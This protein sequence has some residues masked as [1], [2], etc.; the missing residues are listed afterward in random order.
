M[1]T[2]LR[3]R[4]RLHRLIS[5]RLLASDCEIECQITV[6]PGFDSQEIHTRFAAMKLWLEDFVDNSIA[7]NPDSEIDINWIS[8]LYNTAIM[9]PGE[10]MDHILAALI[11]AKL[12]AI[13]VGVVEISRTHF[14]CDTSHGFSNA[15]SGSTAEW[16]PVMSEW[17]GE[18]HFHK[19]PW[20]H[21][22]DATTIDLQPRE[23]DDL[24][25]IPDLGGLLVD[26]VR[27]DDHPD[28]DTNTDSKSNS[29]EAKNAEIIKLRTK[30]KLVVSNEDD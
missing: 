5:D 29:S 15:I 10:P 9:T 23:G 28:D 22:G 12:N 16:L 13:G 1:E 7:Y 26:M 27:L 14:L 19:L 25:N 30:P 3:H 21:R 4:F 6:L 17:I 8:S 18:R 2:I 20:W 24:D 11:H